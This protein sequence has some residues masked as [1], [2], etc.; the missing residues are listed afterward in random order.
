MVLVPCEDIWRLVMNV[1]G[2][3]LWVYCLIAMLRR[4]RMCVPRA[5]LEVSGECL[6][7]C[8]LWMYH[9]ISVRKYH[10][11]LEQLKNEKKVKSSLKTNSKF[12]IFYSIIIS[13]DIQSSSGVK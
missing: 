4:R 8:A 10:H 9:Y 6:E 2:F 1:Y 12:I 13:T 7:V 3:G 11:H 5:C